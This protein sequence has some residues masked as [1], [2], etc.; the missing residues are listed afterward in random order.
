VY[1]SGNIVKKRKIIQVIESM[2]SRPMYGKSFKRNDLTFFNDVKKPISDFD[3]IQ[4]LRKI[5]TSHINQVF[6]INFI[7]NYEK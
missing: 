3:I 2:E 4:I 1:L 5:L 7:E 6:Y